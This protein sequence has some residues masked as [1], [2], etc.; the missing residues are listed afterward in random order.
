M[1]IGI[2]TWGNRISPVFDSS[3]TLTIV[4][5]E[6]LKILNRR[7]EILN[8]KITPRIVSTLQDLQINVLICG[9]ITENQ[10]KVIEKQ[11]IRLISFITGTVDKVLA[12]YLGEPHRMSQFLMPGGRIDSPLEHPLFY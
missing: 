10:S 1:K 3:S 2:T 7:V 4:R 6:N 5:V 12:S 8:P 11:G 9:A